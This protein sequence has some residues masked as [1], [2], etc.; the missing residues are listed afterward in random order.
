MPLADYETITNA[1][2]PISAGKG[3]L[4][5]AAF[6]FE[7]KY[8]AREYVQLAKTDADTAVEW[9]DAKR[10]SRDARLFDGG[11]KFIVV[12]VD[13]ELAKITMEYGEVFWCRCADIAMQ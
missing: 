5:N 10:K 1:T 2:K 12:T 3:I 11:V 4:K 7:D 13:G 8:T 6:L 9:A